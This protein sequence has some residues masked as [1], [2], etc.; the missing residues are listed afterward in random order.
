[1]MP[2]ITP[3]YCIG[4]G[5]MPSNVTPTSQDSSPSDTPTIVPSNVGNREGYSMLAFAIAVGGMTWAFAEL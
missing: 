4:N 3:A 2:T 5:T 1:M